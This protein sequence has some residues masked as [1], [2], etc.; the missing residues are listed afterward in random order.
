MTWCVACE[1]QTIGGL[2]VSL[3]QRHINIALRQYYKRHICFTIMP[4]WLCAINIFCILSYGQVCPYSAGTGWRHLISRSP[5][6]SSRQGRI[7]NISGNN[8]GKRGVLLLPHTVVR[9]RPCCNTLFL[10]L[11]SN[12]PPIVPLKIAAGSSKKTTRYA[13]EPCGLHLCYWSEYDT[14][15]LRTNVDC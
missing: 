2:P 4:P 9:S 3:C 12:K 13:S 14:A 5:A 8:I 11:A 1:S 6:R 7:N 15:K 10:L